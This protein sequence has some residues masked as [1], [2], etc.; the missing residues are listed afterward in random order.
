MATLIIMGSLY[1]GGYPSGLGTEYQSGQSIEIGKS[2]LGKEISWVVANGMLVANRCILTKV[3]WMDLNDNELALGKEINIGGVRCVARLPRVGVKEGVP[4]EWDAAL[5]VAGEDDDLW[6]WKDSYFWGREIP[7]IV[8]SRAVR[9]RLSARNWNGSHA[10]NR[11]ALGFR[12]VLLPLHT[13]R[14]GDVM[15]GNTVV[16]W[17]GQ[18]I[19]FGQLEQITDYEVVLSHWDGALSSADN[20][21][22][23]ISKGQLVVDRGSILGVQKN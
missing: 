1:L 4:N 9:G 2:V 19:V 18:N 20:F 22:V 16:L 10:K 23:Q 8:S 3:S 15:A 14:L 11:G 12:P 7:E 13:D 5:D 21:S 6:H 17:G